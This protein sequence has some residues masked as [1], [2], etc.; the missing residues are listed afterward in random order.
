MHADRHSGSPTS[1]R[2]NDARI[3]TT[4]HVR[5]GIGGNGDGTTPRSGGPQSSQLWKESPEV[6][7]SLAS[8][9]PLDLGSQGAIPGRGC[10]ITTDVEKA[11]IDRRPEREKHP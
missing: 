9:P 6:F 11:I 1:T 2:V 10:V 5:N 8:Q 3:I 4:T 7:G